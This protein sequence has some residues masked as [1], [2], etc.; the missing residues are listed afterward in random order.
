M[1]EA[2]DLTLQSDGDVL[3]RLRGIF[4]DVEAKEDK[5]YVRDGLQFCKIQL[6]AG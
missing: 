4:S 2:D 1:S 6:Q 3:G 5:I